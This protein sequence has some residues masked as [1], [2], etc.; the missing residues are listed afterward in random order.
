MLEVG[1]MLPPVLYFV[2]LFF[3]TYLCLRCP[4]NAKTVFV[5]IIRLHYFESGTRP[6]TFLK[7][8]YLRKLIIAIYSAEPF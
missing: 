8:N 6:S 3:L 2:F 4:Y 5:S 1:G 7:F